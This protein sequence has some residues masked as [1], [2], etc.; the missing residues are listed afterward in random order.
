VRD[1]L[2]DLVA[3]QPAEHELLDVGERHEI[4][5][6]VGEVHD[7]I[8]LNTRARWWR[9]LRLGHERGSQAHGGRDGRACCGEGGDPSRRTCEAVGREDRAV[10]AAVEAHAR[11]A[12]LG[13]RLVCTQERDHL[14]RRHRA[15]V[16][17]ILVALRAVTRAI[18][19]DHRVP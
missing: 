1:A 15:E 13:Q 4:A 9:G 11:Q 2:V 6:V 14:A 18:I 16:E 5:R 7:A 19:A 12:A 17:H 10:L 3:G 8:G